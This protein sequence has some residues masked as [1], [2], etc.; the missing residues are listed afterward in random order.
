MTQTTRKPLALVTG[1]SNGIGLELAKQ[2][3]RH[4]YD[5][6][7]AA[8]D[9][10]IEE[11]PA[12]LADTPAAVRTVRTDLRKPN[13]VEKLW[14][15][16]VAE[17]RP[18]AAA[19]LNAGVGMGRSFVDSDLKDDLDVVDLNV[20]STVHL[21]KLVLDDMAARNEGKVLFTSSVAS[22]MPG[23]YQS[24]YNASK[25]FIQS[26][27]EAVRDELRGT[28]VTVTAL[29]PGPTDTNFFHRAKLDDTIVGKMSGKDDPAQVARQ[30]F[31]ALMRGDAKV[32]GGSL[33]SKVMGTV[34]RVLPDAVKAVGSRVIS[35]PR[36]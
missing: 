21:A 30:G 5:L 22:M 32:V 9:A 8:E 34:S 36:G 23:S 7:V 16:T 10:G 20:R 29:M 27:S 31:Q 25:S 19:A 18:V 28:D 4:G 3:A 6:V 12:K 33:S 26:F 14:A 1:A 2:F 11:V 35:K 15:T 13:E 24:V 17:G